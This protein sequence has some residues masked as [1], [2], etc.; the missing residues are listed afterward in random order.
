MIQSV[1]ISFVTISL[2][3]GLIHHKQPT[4]PETSTGAEGTYELVVSAGNNKFNGTLQLALVQERL[5]GQITLALPGN[6]INLA[7]QTEEPTKT[8]LEF[9]VSSP[10]TKITAT[11]SGDSIYGVLFLT[12]GRA[13][14]YT[15]KKTNQSVNRILKDAFAQ[16]PIYFNHSDYGTAFSTMS[17]NEMYLLM[18]TY[19]EDFTN[20][21]IMILEKDSEGWRNANKVSF[22]G[23]FSDRSPH[24]SHDGRWLY[25]ASTR[26]P[27]EDGSEEKSYNLWRVSFQDGSFGKPEI[28]ADLSSEGN[29]YQPCVTKKG[30]YFISDRKG[31]KGGQDVYFAAYEGNGFGSPVNVSEVNSNSS[32]ISVYVD[33]GE[34]IML[35]ATSSPGDGHQGNDDLYRFTRI[36]E[37]WT[38]SINLG[39]TVN[40]FANEYGAFLSKDKNTLYYTSDLLPPGKLMSRPFKID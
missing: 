17:I 9:K 24:C 28:L 35:L 27:I 36:S 11:T 22:S 40:T 13:F 23:K 16:L 4:I 29:D 6:T 5:V 19:I 32:E 20:Q 12:H 30:I 37:K 34:G 15:G 7:I 2:T 25:F 26:P 8:L 10:A 18:S 21:S 39:S 38:N 1:L 3:G 14:P 31:G 33:P